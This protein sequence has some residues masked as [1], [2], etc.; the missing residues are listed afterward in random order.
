MLGRMPFVRRPLQEHHPQECAAA[1][2]GVHLFRLLGELLPLRV[3][4]PLEETR[5]VLLGVTLHPA[6]QGLAVLSVGLF[7][8]N[9]PNLLDPRGR[10]QAGQGVP[11]GQRQPAQPMGIV[12]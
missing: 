11:V 12:L 2:R 6:Q 5:F 9:E 1:G 10:L 7:L 3:T 4:E 8:L